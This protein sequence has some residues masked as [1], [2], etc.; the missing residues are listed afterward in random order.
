M[1]SARAASRAA[2]GAGF[3]FVAAPIAL[4][5]LFGAS[6]CGPS[7]FLPESLVNGVRILASSAT[8]PYAKPGDA[9]TLNVLTAD[10][11]NN[12]TPAA[13]VSWI[14]IVCEDPTL[15]LYYACFGTFADGGVLLAADGAAPASTS[16]AG[17]DDGGTSADAGATTTTPL[18]GGFSSLPTGVDLTPFL[19]TGPS[20]SF[21]M[22]DGRHHPAPGGR[23]DAPVR[24]GRPLQCHLRRP[25]RIHGGDQRRPAGRN[26]A[27]LLRF[28]PRG[29]GLRQLRLRAHPRVRLQRPAQRQPGDRQRGLRRRPSTRPWA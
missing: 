7:A 14:P 10:A 1:K 18:P 9:V 16:D 17:D 23:G 12:P 11:R 29:A 28:E 26:P 3:G 2:V 24:P 27:R 13:T 21:T 25:P 5:A 4:A 6:S 8:E 19:P 20:F 22:P 15:D